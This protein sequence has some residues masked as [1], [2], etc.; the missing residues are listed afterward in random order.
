MENKET[1]KVIEVT[2]PKILDLI[3]EIYGEVEVKQ[4]TKHATK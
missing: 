2:D 1:V 3:K 4:E